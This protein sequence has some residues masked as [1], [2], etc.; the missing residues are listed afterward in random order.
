MMTLKS[1]SMRMNSIVRVEILLPA[2]DDLVVRRVDGE[3]LGP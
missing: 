3:L 2:D 1:P